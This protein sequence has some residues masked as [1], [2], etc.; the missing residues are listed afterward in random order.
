[1][2]NLTLIAFS[3]CITLL[4]G[5]LASRYLYEAWP[6]DKEILFREFLTER[7]ETLRWRFS[8]SDGHNKLGNL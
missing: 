2:K 3:L 7:D 5:E 8:S 4:L 1:M 6:F